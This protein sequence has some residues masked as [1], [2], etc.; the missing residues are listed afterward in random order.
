MGL[1]AGIWLRALQL[2]HIVIHTALDRRGYPVQNLE[3]LIT[4]RN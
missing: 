1:L 4:Y 2:L 3:K